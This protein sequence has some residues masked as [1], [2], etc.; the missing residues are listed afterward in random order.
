MPTDGKQQE[1]QDVKVEE[2][3]LLQEDK[4]VEEIA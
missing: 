4:K 1:S 3:W 2:D